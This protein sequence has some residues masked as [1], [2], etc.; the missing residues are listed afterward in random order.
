M[1]SSV[2]NAR[3]ESIE[4]DANEGYVWDADDIPPPPPSTFDVTS[5]QRR[6]IK[7]IHEDG[8]RKKQA[9]HFI[10]YIENVLP[11]QPTLSD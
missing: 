2:W 3:A 10:V 1:S 9:F 8:S 5:L 6:D 4:M 7:Q 11:F